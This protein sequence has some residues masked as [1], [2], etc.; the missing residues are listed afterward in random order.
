MERKSAMDRRRNPEDDSEEYDPDQVTEDIRGTEGAGWVDE[1]SEDPKYL[2][3]V[4]YPYTHLD[5]VSS[6][7]L[8]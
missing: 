3:K 7:D 4:T 1:A 8:S 5:D 6:N 2:T